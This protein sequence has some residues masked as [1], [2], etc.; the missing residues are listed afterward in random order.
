[1]FFEFN[2][3]KKILLHLRRWI[4]WQLLTLDYTILR[5]FARFAPISIGR[6]WACI[7]GVIHA[8]FGYDWYTHA[9]GR[10]KIRPLVWSSLKR[11]H[12]D[13]PTW[14]LLLAIVQRYIANSINDFEDH[15]LD[16]LEKQLVVPCSGMS[17]QQDV[18]K[19]TIYCIFHYA[20]YIVGVLWLCKHGRPLHIVASNIFL[21]TPGIHPLVRGMYTK[22]LQFLKYFLNGGDIHYVEDGML[23]IH[24]AIHRGED[25][26][27]AIDLTTKSNK[28]MCIDFLGLERVPFAAGVQNMVKGTGAFWR[29]FTCEWINGK[30]LFSLGDSSNDPM[31]IFKA[32]NFFAKKI[33]KCPHLWLAS[34]VL[35]FHPELESVHSS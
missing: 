21:R 20:S 33:D 9:T 3:L 19:A 4:V 6:C 25:V 22:R 27:I 11:I 5:L 23:P 15:A 10:Y 1:M 12:S 29:P 17:I 24:R 34:F 32:Y 35:G 30:Y 13:W 16:R 2:V 31:E 28:C 18:H 8:A 26:I 14:R 7:R